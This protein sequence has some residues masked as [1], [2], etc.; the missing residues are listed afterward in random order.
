MSAPHRIDRFT[1]TAYARDRWAQV[2][3]AALAIALSAS[4]L[5]VLGVTP[6]GTG[7]VCLLLGL[8]ALSCFVLGY[9]R[10]A[11]SLNDLAD[12]VEAAADAETFPTHPE[13]DP[14]DG[15]ALPLEAR[16]VAQSCSLIASAAGADAAQARQD[17]EEYHRYI[18]AWIHEVKAPMAAIALVN[19][20]NPGPA[21]SK[22]SRELERIQSHVDQALYYARSTTRNLDYAIRETD[23]NH[24]VREACL[25]NA[26]FL[27]DHGCTPEFH[28]PEGL[29]VLADTPWLEFVL[30]QLTV[31][32]AKY[33]ATTLRFSAWEQDVETPAGRTTLEVADN[34]WGIPA[35]DM[36][37][38]FERGY[39]G[40]NGREQGSATGMGLHLVATLCQ[41]MGLHVGL[42]SEAGVGTRVLI[43]FPHDRTV[44]LRRCEQS[45]V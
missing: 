3:V 24:A 14:D 20:Q 30:G 6:E 25:R 38:V 1:P 28:I 4:L 21:A 15:R 36:P 12:A 44:L 42:A 39:T 37:R 45:P 29:T 32:A 33:G 17:A 2:V 31:N 22:V 26:R 34:G 8:A 23:L 35:A 40:L 18:E 10:Q 27:I 9:L 19:A 16:I 41:A 5:H 7:F 13:I 11:S 43:T